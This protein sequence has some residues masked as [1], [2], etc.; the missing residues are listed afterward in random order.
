MKTNLTPRMRQLLEFID[1]Y[2]NRHGYSPCFD[3]MKEAMG[4]KSKSGIHRILGS[5]EER[6]C[7]RRRKDHPRAIEILD[8][9]N[10]ALVP[11]SADLMA[12]IKR[13]SSSLG[14]TPA[15]YVHSA[16][17]RALATDSDA[18]TA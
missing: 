4:L 17:Y 2:S 18:R 11:I 8:D 3:E 16:I 1:E 6:G 7:I 12:L 5:L 14:L 13:A 9:R 15:D 10:P